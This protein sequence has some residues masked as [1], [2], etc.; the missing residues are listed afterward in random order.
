[1][2]ESGWYSLG[3]HVGSFEN[4][5]AEYCGAD[6]CIGVANGTD[7]LELALRACG[8]GPGRDVVTVANAGGYSTTAILAAGAEPVYADISRDDMLLDTGRLA[9]V[10]TAN[11]AAV[12]ATHLYGRMADMP[13]VLRVARPAGI[14]VVEDCAQAHGARLQG[15]AAGA[16]G[17]AGCFS[18]YPTKNLGALGDGGA[19]VT[20][21]AEFAARVRRLRQY[22][23][24]EKY[25]SAEAGGRNSR[26]DEIQAA[27]LLEQL[28]LLD[29][30]NRRRRD[31][32]GRYGSEL[33]NTGLSLPAAGGMEYVAHLYVVASE[34]R[35]RIR[36][37]LTARG[38]GT[39]VHYPVPDHRQPA[40]A[41][42]R[43]AQVSLP[44]TEQAA[45][46]VL[47]IPCFPELTDAE[48]DAVV[49]ALCVE[50]PLRSTSER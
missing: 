14:P 17:I 33:R 43:W 8:A 10:I 27:F 2:I 37:R 23:W 30:W 7:A 47:T 18:F 31:I 36:Q 50:D 3:P 42:C 6:E 32:A 24:S 29:E 40:W 48:V 38:V 11:T 34:D 35:D 15:R 20:S 21:D 16:W 5:F 46:R 22:G 1:V 28:P 19:I 45:A 44:E 41:H 49:E 26:L 12:I 39:D 25:R 4:A 9:S 13:A